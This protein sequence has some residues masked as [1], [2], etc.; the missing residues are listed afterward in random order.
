MG[1]SEPEQ[2]ALPLR[3][4]PHSERLA[5]WRFVRW[6]GLVERAAR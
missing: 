4:R 1:G 2:P 3:P 6:V 5:G